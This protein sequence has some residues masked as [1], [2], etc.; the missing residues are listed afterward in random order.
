MEHLLKKYLDSEKHYFKAIFTLLL[1][2][3]SFIIINIIFILILMGV[4]RV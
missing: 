4:N 3:L 2:L 1:S